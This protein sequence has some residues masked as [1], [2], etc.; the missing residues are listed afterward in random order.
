MTVLDLD[1]MIKGLWTDNYMTI[2]QTSQDLFKKYFSRYTLKGC[3][4]P[5][6]NKLIRQSYGGGKVETFALGAIR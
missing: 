2:S 3:N 1:G 6:I 4:Q 5:A